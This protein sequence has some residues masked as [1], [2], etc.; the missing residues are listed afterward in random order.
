MAR[1]SKLRP[2]TAA[3]IVDFC[4]AA[5]RNRLAIGEQ[6]AERQG[7]HCAGALAEAR[8]H[9]L[10]PPDDR[11]AGEILLDEGHEHLPLLPGSPAA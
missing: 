2:R 5:G 1:R 3:R 9:D 6:P 7:A 10:G 11:Q 4:L 8:D